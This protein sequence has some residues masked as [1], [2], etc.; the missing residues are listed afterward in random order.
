MLQSAT[1]FDAVVAAKLNQGGFAVFA[2][3]DSE[4]ADP[5]DWRSFDKAVR[6]ELPLQPFSSIKTAVAVRNES[7]PC[8]TSVGVFE[9]A[10]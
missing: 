10:V 9:V 5:S 4:P 1:E 6:I 8:A 7:A 2:W 3:A